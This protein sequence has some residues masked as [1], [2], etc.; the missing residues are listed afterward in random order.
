[1]P[2][3]A[4]SPNKSTSRDGSVVKISCTCGCSYGLTAITSEWSQ[5]W[6]QYVTTTKVFCTDC[7]TTA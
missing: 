1:M 3:T 2:T 6:R 4:P 5:P 7:G